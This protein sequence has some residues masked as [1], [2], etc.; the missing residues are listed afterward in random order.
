LHMPMHNVAGY[1]A[2]HWLAYAHDSVM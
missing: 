1:V 2:G